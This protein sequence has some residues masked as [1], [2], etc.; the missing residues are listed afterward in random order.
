M[1][2]LKKAQELKEKFDKLT[3]EHLVVFS[4]PASECG[5]CSPLLEGFKRDAK[6]LLKE[7]EK[8]CGKEIWTWHGRY[9]RNGN[10]C[11]DCQKAKE[12]CKEILK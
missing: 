6:K 5:A 7:I 9:C 4:Y 12:L 1:N 2:N 8:G 11:P 10:L 3:K